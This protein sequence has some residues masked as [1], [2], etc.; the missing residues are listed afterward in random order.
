MNATVYRTGRPAKKT[1][2]SKGTSTRVVSRIGR[3]GPKTVPGA[4]WIAPAENTA[5]NYYN[6]N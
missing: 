5:S 6:V 3:I 4:P 2:V 1:I